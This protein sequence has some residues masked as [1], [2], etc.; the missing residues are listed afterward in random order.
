MTAPLQRQPRSPVRRIKDAVHGLQDLLARAYGQPG[1]GML[2][3]LV[4]DG[5]RVIFIH[6]PKAGGTSLGKFLGVKRRS[7]SFPEDRLS[8]RN[9]QECYSIVA[10]RDPF[11]RFLSGYFDHV[12]K[13]NINA[14][15]R[16][17]GPAFKQ[18]SPFEYLDILL[19]NPKFGGSQLHW[20]D[21]PSPTKPRSDLVLR[22]EEISLWGEKLTA[23]GLDMGR[24]T[25]P[26]TNRGPRSSLDPRTALNLSPDAF[27]RLEQTVRQAFRPDAL[28]FGYPLDAEPAGSAI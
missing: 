22:Y 21:Y 28:A 7:H 18:A 6:N 5:R 20:T 1:D 9:W 13:P 8:P 12:R 14:L 16:M 3:D 10:I 24:R 25:L 2:T 11:D 19:E 4:L 27:V 26:H 15:T 17:Y 23:V